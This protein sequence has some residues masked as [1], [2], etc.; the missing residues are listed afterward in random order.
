LSDLIGELLDNYENCVRY[1]DVVVKL[2]RIEALLRE[3]LS[4]LSTRV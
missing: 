4:K 1:N 2:G 3:C